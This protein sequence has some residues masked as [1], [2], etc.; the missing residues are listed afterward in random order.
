MKSRLTAIFLLA[1]AAVVLVSLEGIC[2][3]TTYH[4]GI[5]QVT[6][7]STWT[8]MSDRMLEEAMKV[9]VAGGR[10]LA[11]DSKSADP[12]DLSEKTIRFVSGFQ[13][14]SASKRI[15]LTFLGV[16]SPIIMDREDM[17][18]TNAERVKWGINTGRLRKTSKGVSK[19]EIDGITCLLQDV[20]TIEGGR[21][22]MYSFFVPE[23]PKMIYS[24]QII[25]DDVATFNR[26]AKDLSAI[27]KSIK[28]VKKTRK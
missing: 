19:L 14:Q 21:L 9:A 7:P 25:C 10:E 22:Q 13:L 18:K 1:C 16:T 6:L 12:N 28:V 8:R 11:E 27:V 4:E 24:L 23:Y 3:Y 17:Y 26:H 2:E 20:E 15:L 5:F